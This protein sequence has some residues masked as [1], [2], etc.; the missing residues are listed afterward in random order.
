[1]TKNLYVLPEGVEPAG[2]FVGKLTNEKAIDSLNEQT[3]IVR[4]ENRKKENAERK[5]G[6]ALL[7]VKRSR[8]AEVI[9]PLSERN[10]RGQTAFSEWYKRE[11]V[12]PSR[13][14]P[15]IAWAVA[16]EKAG[17]ELSAGVARRLKPVEDDQFDTVL[18]KAKEIASTRKRGGKKVTQADVIS[19][20]SALTTKKRTSGKK[21]PATKDGKK[22]PAADLLAAANT[23]K[24]ELEKVNADSL[25]KSQR[26][27]LNRLAATITKLTKKN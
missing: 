23:F 26:E 13:V 16:E 8:V 1:M 7:A 24:L 4:S 6:H 27:Y 11:G 15:L 19:A 12:D 14:E 2:T 9:I 3:K 18:E 25:T 10:E 21:D 5:L 22:D 17:E 20:R